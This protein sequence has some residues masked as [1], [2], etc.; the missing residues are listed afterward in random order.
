[1]ASTDGPTHITEIDMDGDGDTD[2]II[3][4]EGDDDPTIP[5]QPP[6]PPTP[7]NP[8]E[9]LENDE[10]WDDARS[11]VEFAIMER[12]FKRRN[13]FD[14][15]ASGL[16]PNGPES[17]WPVTPMKPDFTF[18]PDPPTSGDTEIVFEA[19]W[20]VPNNPSHTYLWTFGGDG[21]STELNPTHTFSAPATYAVTL[22]VTNTLS[23]Q[24]AT[25]DPVDVVIV[26]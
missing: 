6:V 3:I 14:V 20:M 16:S 11:Q 2:V 18:T 8:E 15:G 9:M 25:S 7:A 26:A 4:T 23:G 5:P 17:Q 13:A 21:T 22:A 24:T 19:G 1:M 12:W 10:A